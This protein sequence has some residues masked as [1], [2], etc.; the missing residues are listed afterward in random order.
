MEERR[1]IA[2]RIGLWKELDGI[3]KRLHPEL[4]LCAHETGTLG[5]TVWKQNVH[6]RVERGIK[7]VEEG[8]TNDAINNLHINMTDINELPVYLFFFSL[9]LSDLLTRQ[10]LLFILMH[11]KHTRMPSSIERF[12]LMIVSL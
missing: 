9:I 5:R 4:R 2:F 8:K 11:H 10:V 12:I 7:Q 3:G 6:L 1:L